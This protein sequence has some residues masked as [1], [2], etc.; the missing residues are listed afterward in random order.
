MKTFEEPVKLADAILQYSRSDT[1]LVVDCLTLWLTNLLMPHGD[2]AAPFQQAAAEVEYAW[3]LPLVAAL[4]SASGP[5][6]LVGNEIGLG[7][8]PLGREARHF[9]DALG[10]LNQRRRGSARASR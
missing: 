5:M 6:V 10:H 8:I 1:L 3:E 9:V 4:E 2:R 7:V